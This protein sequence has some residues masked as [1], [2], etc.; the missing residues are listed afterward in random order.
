MRKK[1]EEQELS[2]TGLSLYGQ[3]QSTVAV[4]KTNLD[5]LIQRFEDFK[6]EIDGFV[7]DKEFEPVKNIVYGFVSLILVSVAGALIAL[8]VIK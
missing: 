8:V 2:L 4:I 7:T 1:N 3:L 5:N 6:D